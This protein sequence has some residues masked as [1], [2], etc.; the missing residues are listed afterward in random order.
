MVAIL[1]VNADAIPS[2]KKIA[3]LTWQVTYKEILSA[4]QMDYMLHLFY[5]EDA[6]QKQIAQGHQ[7]ILAVENNEDVG[8]ASYSLKENEEDVIYKLDKI[9]VHPNQ[10]GKSIG[11]ILLNYIINDIKTK[12]AFGLELNVNRHNRALHFYQKNGFEIIKEED[13]D[14][15]NGYFMNDYVMLKKLIPPHNLF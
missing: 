6:L 9:Y 12:N 4:E 2:I 1:Q 14:I 15:G 7:F 3:N 8:F 10:Q 11:K 5:D 13:I